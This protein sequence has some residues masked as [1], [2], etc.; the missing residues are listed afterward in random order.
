ML[1]RLM[2]R[3]LPTSSQR[4]PIAEEVLTTSLV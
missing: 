2:L 3:R 1:R 4:K